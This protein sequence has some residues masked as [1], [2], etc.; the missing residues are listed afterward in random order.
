MLFYYTSNYECDEEI[1]KEIT[2]IVFFKPLI[3]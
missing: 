1:I 3:K 2:N